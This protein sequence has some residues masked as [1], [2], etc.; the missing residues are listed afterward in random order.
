MSLATMQIINTIV[1]RNY[2]PNNLQYFRTLH[3]NAALKQN[4]ILF[5]HGLL[6]A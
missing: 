6:W 2:I 3:I 1:E 5:S 4:N